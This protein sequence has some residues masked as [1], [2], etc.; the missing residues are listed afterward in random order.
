MTEAA[1]TPQEWVRSIKLPSGHSAG[2]V[3]VAIA[4]VCDT[5]LGYTYTSTASIAARA[6]LDADQIK[7]TLA[8]LVRAEWIYRYRRYTA[9]GIRTADLIV[10]SMGRSAEEIDALA[11]DLLDEIA[12]LNHPK[13]PA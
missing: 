9:A 1:L 11:R 8:L 6:G 7:T 5:K 4:D 3:L 10:L 13:V 2:R 12:S